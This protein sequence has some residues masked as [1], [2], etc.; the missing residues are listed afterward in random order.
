MSGL[1]RGVVAI[2]AF[3][4]YGAIALVVGGTGGLGGVA[5][6]ALGAVGAGYLVGSPWALLM[7]A[8]FALYGAVNIGNAGPLENTDSGWGALILLAVALPVAVCA[9]I[10]IVVRRRANR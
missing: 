8:P 3:L 10:G 4:L 5:L 1:A 2:P 7:A 6:I 9:A